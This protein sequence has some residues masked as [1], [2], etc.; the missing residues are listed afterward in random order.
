MTTP[1]EFLISG[2]F[3]NAFFQ[4]WT[5][6]GVPGDIIYV[7]LITF[8]CAVIYVK[9]KEI[10]LVGLTLLMTSPFLITFVTPTSQIYFAGLLIFGI[11]SLIYWFFKGRS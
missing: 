10:G 5:D 1:F 9:T 8:A 3:L 4:V 7:T 11:A 6:A 2:D